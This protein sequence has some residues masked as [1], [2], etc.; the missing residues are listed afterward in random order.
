MMN[1][2]MKFLFVVALANMGASELSKANNAAAAI[3]LK[4]AA[5]K[6]AATPAAD[7]APAKSAAPAP[8]PVVAPV[9]APAPATPT[10]ATVSD[11]ALK[12]KLAAVDGAYT[13][14]LKAKTDAA[15]I[16]SVQTTVKA[17]DTAATA[18][19]KAGGTIA[20]SYDFKTK[21]GGTKT[22]Q[23]SIVTTARAVKAVK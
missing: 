15:K 21:S 12:S 17:Y 11:S 20:T 14:Y 10:V 13:A 23:T 4:A 2:V 22:I 9:A 7:T 18:Y 16:K 3:E 6:A 19:T 8:A 5:S 1:N